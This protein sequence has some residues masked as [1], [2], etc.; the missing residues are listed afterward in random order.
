MD[1]SDL[2][3]ASARPTTAVLHYTA[4]MVVGGVEAVIQA[5][6]QVFAKNGY[7]LTVIVGRGDSEALHPHSGFTLVPEMDSQHPRIERLNR[8]LERGVLPEEFERLVD[9]LEESLAPLVEGFDNIIVHNIFTKHFNLPL[10]AALF[11]L[12]DRQIIKNCIAWCHDFSWTSPNS[13]KK[14]HTGYP[15]D[16]L[17]THRADVT[18][19]TISEERR[20]RLADLLGCRPELIHVVYNGVDPQSLLGISQEGLDLAE[21]LE[22]L[23]SDLNLLMPIRVTRAKNIEFALEVIAALKSRGSNPK[24]VLTGPPDPHDAESVNYFHSLQA[25]RNKL[26]VEREMR[27]VFES[28]PDPQQTYSIE[29]QVVGDLYRLADV[30]F[31]PSHREGFG[32][33]VLEAGLAGVPV[34]CSPMPAAVEIGG[35]DV[36]FLSEKMTPDEAAGLI[37]KLAEGSQVLRLRRKVR[38]HYTWRSIFRRQILPLLH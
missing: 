11:H 32:M 37:V 9:H 27:F 25:L 14:M 36:L 16:L 3:S 5:H 2:D 17:R 6:A 30:M 28:G 26:G 1:N 33:P 15:W 34:V 13:R 35:R 18:Y 8:R 12:L 24:L 7:P 29:A 4:P 20:G 22:L 23:D 10:T 31:M 21:R 19:V 38:Q